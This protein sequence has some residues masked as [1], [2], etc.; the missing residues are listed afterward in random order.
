MFL[1]ISFV[2]R[3]KTY[4]PVVDQEEPAKNNFLGAL[5]NPPRG[6]KIKTERDTNTQCEANE[7]EAHSEHEYE[8]IDDSIMYVALCFKCS[9]LAENCCEEM[10]LL[11]VCVCLC[12]CM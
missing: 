6:T 8:S 11:Y 2:H 5:P 3:D 7:D 9:N 10:C 12:M 1:P 4:N